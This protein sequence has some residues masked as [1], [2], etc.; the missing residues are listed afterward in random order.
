MEPLSVNAPY[1]TTEGLMPDCYSLGII[2]PA[3][4]SSSGEL[5]AVLQYVYHSL[6]FERCG[7][8]KWAEEISAIAVSEMKHLALL[9][10]TISLL[11]ARPVYCQNPASAFGYYSAKFVAYSNSLLHMAEDDVIA[12]RHAIAGY[13]RMLKRLK[14]EQ[15]KAIIARIL[16]DEYLHLKK[17]TNIAEELKNTSAH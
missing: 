17:F 6:E 15:V 10:K 12:E 3:Y 11:G 5:N 7:K 1:P 9:G 2:S 4:A 14:N 16:E 13:E 8:K